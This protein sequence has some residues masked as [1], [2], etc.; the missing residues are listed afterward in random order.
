[1]RRPFVSDPIRFGSDTAFFDGESRKWIGAATIN[2]VASW[3]KPEWRVGLDAVVD[4]G[5]SQTPSSIPWTTLLG[6]AGVSHPEQPLA[7]VH[8]LR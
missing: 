8:W 7:H 3:G 2:R 1:M 4:P 5:A 6:F